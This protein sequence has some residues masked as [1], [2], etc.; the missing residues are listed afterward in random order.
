MSTDNQIVARIF[1]HSK[2]SNHFIDFHVASK[3]M[4]TNTNCFVSPAEKTA[5]LSWNLSSVGIVSIENR[6]AAGACD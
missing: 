6:N 1:I 2:H 3:Y 4:G 5:K